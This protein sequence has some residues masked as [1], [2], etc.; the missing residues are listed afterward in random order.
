[1]KAQAKSKVGDLRMDSAAF[2]SA[3]RRALGVHPKRET[4]TARKKQ[5]RK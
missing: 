3:M 2:D 4:K 5:R 1:M